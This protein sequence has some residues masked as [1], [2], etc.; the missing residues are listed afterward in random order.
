MRLFGR[1]K[2]VTKR[3]FT[4]ATTEWTVY[5]FS[6]DL[7]QYFHL[8]LYKDM[9]DLF[10]GMSEERRARA[11]GEL[12]ILHIFGM[13][14]QLFLAGAPFEAQ[15]E[16]RSAVMNLVAID[17]PRDMEPK[18]MME[19]RCAQY[20]KIWGESGHTG[21]L[22]IAVAENIFTAQELSKKPAAK[23][24]AERAIMRAFNNYMKDTAKMLSKYDLGS[25]KK[26]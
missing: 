9:K 17:L 12:V 14:E 23:L 4:K 19:F 2:R 15:D 18:K 21:K 6:R 7:T 1:K 3:E 13:L 22:G 26:G 8:D 16:Y 25:F 11:I 24:M 10:T 20:R 5:G